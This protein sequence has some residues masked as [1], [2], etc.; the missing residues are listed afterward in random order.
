MVDRDAKP[1]DAIDAV[2][3]REAIDEMT[4]EA[5]TAAARRDELTAE[6]VTLDSDVFELLGSTHALAVLREF[7]LEGGPLRFSDLEESLS[8]SPSTLTAR[9]SEFVEAGLLERESFDEIPPRVEYRASERTEALVPV[10][11]YLQLWADEYG[12]D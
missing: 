2:L 9:L 1:T 10:F 6:D 11:V 8:I 3:S 12:R 5:I 7:A 4:P